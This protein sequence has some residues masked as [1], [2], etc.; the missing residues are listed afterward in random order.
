MNYT[1]Y[2]DN[3]SMYDSNP[4]IVDEVLMEAYR[5]NM[6]LAAG[7]T[8]EQLTSI[9]AQTPSHETERIGKDQGQNFFYT[10]VM[11]FALYMVILMYGQMISTGVASEKSSRAMEVLITSVKPTAMMFGKVLASCAAGLLQLVAVFG[12]AYLTFQANRSLW[13][14]QQ[15]VTSVFDMPGR[16]LVYMIIFFL[17][18][19]FVY[20]FLY[21]A[22]GSVV[23]KV[24][25]LNTAVMPLMMVF[26]VSFL[27]VMFSLAD[28]TVD[29]LLMKVLS[30]FPLTSPM[31]MFTRIAMST[32]P[33][34]QILISIVILLVSAAAIGVLSARIYRVGVLRY[35]NPLNLFGILKLAKKEE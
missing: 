25:D 33:F 28:G 34:W 29:T 3:L 12:S 32:V 13:E 8:E 19:F 15:M 21:G 9:Y 18:G 7:V 10:Y 2:V 11:L 35:G 1:Y 20:A 26:V 5:T 27:I 17:L 22:I 4:E 14:D 23:T 16:L 31:A 30:Y 24:E 6:L